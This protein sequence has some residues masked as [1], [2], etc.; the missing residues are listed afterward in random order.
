M[1]PIIT[2]AGYK[3]ERGEFSTVVL[4]DGV[5]E[6]CF[7]ADN[8]KATVVSRSA[9]LKAVHDRNVAEFRDN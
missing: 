3:G 8:G 2:R 4:P 6:T 1:K 9:S 5:V 7:F